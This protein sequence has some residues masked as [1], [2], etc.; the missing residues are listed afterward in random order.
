MTEA[1]LSYVDRSAVRDGRAVPFAAVPD[2]PTRGQRVAQWAATVV[3]VVCAIIGVLVV[4]V[5]A[6]VLG[7]A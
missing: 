3:S 6:V 2:E 7:L 4:S 5:A 1:W